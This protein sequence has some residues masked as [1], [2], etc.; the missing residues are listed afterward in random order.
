MWKGFKQN[1]AAF[2]LAVGGR[3]AA[4]SWVTA[5][6]L[7]I[8]LTFFVAVQGFLTAVPVWTRPLPPEVDDS[9]TYVLK[10]RQMEEC[11]R[12]DCLALIDLKAQLE[13]P[14]ASPDVAAARDLVSSRIFPV[15]HPLFS[16]LLLSIKKTGLSLMDA[17]RVVWTAGPVFFG[18]AFAFFLT[19]VWG[20]PAAGLALMLLAFKVFPD[21]GLHHVVPSNLALGLAFLVWARVMARRGAAP[22]TLIAG[23]ILLVGLHP[24]GRIYAVM[25]AALAVVL[26]DEPRQLRVWG[27]GLAAC[28]L[29][30]L[31][32]VISA[33]V[34]EPALAGVFFSPSEGHPILHA[35]VG[36]GQSLFAVL[37]NVSR[38]EDGLFGLQ[39]LFFGAVTLGFLTLKSAQ[40][41]LAVRTAAIYGLFLFGLLFYVSSSPADVIFRVWIGLIVLL[42]GAVGQALWWTLDRSWGLLIER[43]RGGAIGLEKTWP[44]VL[45]AVLAGYAF[46]LSTRGAEQVEATYEHMQYREPLRFEAAQVERLLA[47][48]RPGDRVLYSSMIVMPFYFIYGAMRLGAVYDQPVLRSTPEEAAWLSR[49]ELRFAVTYQPTVYHPSFEGM[50]E[51]S[52]WITGPDYRYSPLSAGR[53]NQPLAINGRIRAADFA[54]IEVESKI[55][56]RP[57]PLS[58][59]VENQGPASVLE[60]V[61]VDA[62]GRLMGD[63][64]RREIVRAGWSGRVS[65]A[66]PEDP[67]LA[68]FRLVFPPGNDLLIEGLVFGHDALYWPWAQRAD[69]TFVYRKGSNVPVTVSF[70]PARRLPEALHGRKITVLDDRGSAVLFRLDR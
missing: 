4:R 1:L 24:V 64:A 45:L 29:V 70:D 48:A 34:R 3:P 17:Y 61:P 18:V 23:T 62:F 9:L 69:L 52:W 50:S 26:A 33:L 58:V 16:L 59:L 20:G 63:L 60:L 67:S 47:E 54:W 13:I 41:R 38:L 2:L 30:A 57:G 7:G 22:W 44:V 55:R 42:F 49:P 32:F 43:L 65:F 53:T 10:T 12:Q 11:F 56:A 6:L 36:A 21:T 35:L 68:R 51:D 31:S 40:R 28:L 8:G 19:R 46:Q 27:G 66:L 5:L 15:Y 37:V 25:A 39:A 14:S